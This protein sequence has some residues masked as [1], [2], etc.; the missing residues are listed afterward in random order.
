MSENTTKFL[1]VI[2]IWQYGACRKTKILEWY[3]T[4]GTK[5]RLYQIS[6]L[7]KWLNSRCWYLRD[8]PEVN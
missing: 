7:I 3:Q 4:V 8:L 2:L 6:F 1:D 5:Y